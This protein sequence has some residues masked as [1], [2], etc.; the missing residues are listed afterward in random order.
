MHYEQSGI[1]YNPDLL[2]S[3]NPALPPYAQN[4]QKEIFPCVYFLE[5]ESPLFYPQC[6]ARDVKN[7]KL[8]GHRMVAAM[9]F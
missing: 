7:S 2:E 8:I 1:A 5:R 4:A 6:N 3:V 9:S